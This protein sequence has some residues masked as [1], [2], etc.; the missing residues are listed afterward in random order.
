MEDCMIFT[1]KD[2]R[3]VVKF[4]DGERWKQKTFHDR[5]AAEGFERSLQYDEEENTRL[6][7]SESILLFLAKTK[8]CEKVRKRYAVILH[9]MGDEI[10]SRY[11]D[12]LDRRDLEHF[13]DKMQREWHMEAGV[14]NV[15]VQKMLAA[16]RWCASEDFLDTVPWAKYRKLP[17]KR[18]GHWCG[19]F[20]DFRKVYALCNS[21]IQW[22]VRTCLA[23][24]LRPGK[25]LANLQWKDVDLQKGS[26]VIFMYKVEREK[27]VFCPAWWLEEAKIRA[28]GA[29]PQ[30]LVCK[31]PRG[32]KLREL[33]HDWHRVCLRAGVKNLPLYT[34]RHLAASLMIEAG[35]DIAA[36]AA[37]LGHKDVTTTGE[38][39]THAMTGAQERAA[40]DIPALDA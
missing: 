12:T 21:A 24:C 4:K 28:I 32:K 7:V 3:F 18:Q 14:I 35:A 26:A 13:R 8:H 25:E 23:L 29:A 6:T 31:S 22:A 38:F 10:G 39:Y 40:Q 20:D 2:G 16:W 27:T 33:G 11:V 15:Y 5:D 17:E 37:Q 1:R 9:R 34:V 30:D 36:V 19:N